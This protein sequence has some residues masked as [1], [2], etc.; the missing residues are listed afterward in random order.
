M[1]Q[2]R[3]MISSCA[4][5]LLGVCVDC[6]GR[7]CV[8]RTMVFPEE[9]SKIVTASGFDG[10]RCWSS[11]IHYLERGPCPY[12]KDGRCSVQDWKPFVCQ[13]FPFVP[14]VIDGEYWLFAVNECTAANLL[15]E[16]FIDNA[17]SLAR[18]YLAALPAEEYAD[19]WGRNKIGD[20]DEEKTVVKIK[21]FD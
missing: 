18:L 4:M 11:R 13:I 12:L 2:V 19:Y 1:E 10:F 21:V 6:N 16:K 7:C 15:S 14:R 3:N 9:R 5:S 20:F 8:G 17:V